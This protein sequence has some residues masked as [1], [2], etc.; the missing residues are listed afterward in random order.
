[1]EFIWSPWRMKYIETHK[2]DDACVFCWAIKQPDDTNNLIV[3]RGITSFLI[4]NRYPYTSGHLMVVS[5]QHVE[6][7]IDLNPQTRA[8]LM[9][10]CEKAIRVLQTVY[11]PHG[12]NVGINIGEAAGAGILEH[13][14]V[15]IVPRWSGDTNFMAA[16][17]DTR[18][19]P[20]QLEDTYE[21]VKKAWHDLIK[22]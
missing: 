13:L 3:Y 18:V 1:M 9:E 8:E 7:L 2:K 5:N 11:S 22:E 10:L 12:F 19:L 21:R 16:L 14:H 6:S 20:E 17:A 15:H 4:L